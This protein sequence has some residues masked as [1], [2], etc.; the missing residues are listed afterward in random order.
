MARVKQTAQ[1]SPGG[2]SPRFHLATMAALQSMRQIGGMR[3]P[4]RYCPGM[5]LREIRKI[6]K[7]T[8]LLIMKAPSQHL[9][10]KLAQKIRKCNL[11]M[12]STAVLALQEAVEY[13]MIDVYSDT[14]LCAMHGKHIT[15]KPKDMVLACHIQGIPMG[16]A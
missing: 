15:I 8:N 12:Q 5:A 7:A 14:N 4:H 10:H 6:Q 9:V 2:K 16:R 13:V 11:G 3:K 1:K